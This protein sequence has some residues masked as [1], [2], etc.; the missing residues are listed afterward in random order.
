[1]AST[2]SSAA[3]WD[4]FDTSDLTP[5]AS[6]ATAAQPTAGTTTAPK[7]VDPASI[8]W[9]DFETSDLIH[10]D[11]VDYG[12]GA[13][14]APGAETGMLAQN[15][16]APT[17]NIA[18]KR[19]LGERAG[20]FAELNNGVGG[21]YSPFI[22][23]VSF[24]AMDEISS[25]GLAPVAAGFNWLKG[26]GPTSLGEAYDQEKAAYLRDKALYEEE[27]RILSGA[28]EIAGSVMSGG[29]GAKFVAGA[30]GF[31][32]MLGRSALIG[33]GEAGAYSALDTEGTLADRLKA[34]ATGAAIGAGAGAFGPLA[35]KGLSAAGRGLA[36]GR[37]VVQRFTNPTAA[38]ENDFVR[39]A[40]RDR[41]NWGA[42]EAQAAA[43]GRPSPK[44]DFGT[45]ADALDAAAMRQTFDVGDLAG[46]R[47][48][49]T[50][51]DA[52]N[53]DA[54]AAELVARRAE[55][56]MTDQGAR[57]EDLAVDLMTPGRPDWLNPAMVT[58]ALRQNAQ[59]VNQR[60][61]REA[62][63]NPAS[64]DVWT[65]GVRGLTGSDS[66]QKAFADALQEHSEDFI[67]K[68]AKSPPPSFKVGA[69]GMLDLDG[70]GG[71]VSL[72]FLDRVQKTL[73]DQVEAAKINGKMTSRATR[74]EGF[75][76]QL[77]EEMDRASTVG[78]ESLYG[79]ARGQAKAFFDAEDSYE[80]GM[81][82][83][84][85]QKAM[86]LSKARQA[87]DGMSD[88]DRE[89]FRQG[90]AAA[91]IDKIAKLPDAKDV[92]A[93]LN[94]RAAR[95][96]LRM[97]LGDDKADAFSAY[98][99]RDGLARAM[100]AVAKKA[101]A[102][103][104]GAAL[105]G[106]LSSTAGA[107]VLGSI[108]GALASGDP[109][110]GGTLVGALFGGAGRAIWSRM[111]ASRRQAYAQAVARLVT[112]DDP[113]EI[114]R[115]HTKIMSDPELARLTTRAASYG[116]RD[117]LRD[118]PL[119]ALTEAP[120]AVAPVLSAES[121]QPDRMSI[122]DREDR[123]PGYARGGGVE[124]PSDRTVERLEALSEL[125]RP[126]L[127][128]PEAELPYPTN[129]ELAARDAYTPR[130]KRGGVGLVTP[131]EG[132]VALRDG[133]LVEAEHSPGADAYLNGTGRVEQPDGRT[134]YDHKGRNTQQLN[135]RGPTAVASANS[136]R[137]TSVTDRTRQ[138]MRPERLR[139]QTGPSD[140]RAFIA[141]I[142][143]MIEA[144]MQGAA[145][146]AEPVGGA[147]GALA[148]DTREPK[149]RLGKDRPAPG[150]AEDFLP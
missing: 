13:Y 50:V 34:G 83:A 115:I 102:R 129:E 97:A 39:A 144:R 54:D 18:G 65:V 22:H 99:H 118:A 142:E 88:I 145:V 71:K 42:A 81:K 89:L 36:A 78:G 123:A 148:A 76:N 52:L 126:A 87:I 33:G 51:K 132:V 68:R 84:S 8:G 25:G 14:G 4:G 108:G 82:F 149:R 66:V 5:A 60:A 143:A 24:G 80:A 67:A 131:G 63:D 117:A 61:Y 10:R 48:R 20:T 94:N 147:L 114:A 146:P 53:E 136:R 17:V 55:S 11:T 105:A 7:S 70:A 31:L 21:Q 49:A 128:R 77:L 124:M 141:Q 32:S 19:D 27:N 57:A 73:R 30:P 91:L 104:G 138:R 37:G 69:D 16:E 116:L 125:Y 9:D 92:E 59:R 75:R 47:A 1:M 28:A 26:E 45:A 72:E 41:V 74:I 98:L 79:K 29:A 6:K 134:I 135:M 121:V 133:G 112:S 110:F 140:D 127:R 46:K 111:S 119:K 15:G 106:E 44:M 96:N 130:K 90:Y 58:E 12:N 120:G 139:S 2:S 43:S 56:R 35:E 64:A 100:G 3:I 122:A 86:D 109:L 40:A 93:L 103:D 38:A 95:Q 85:P 113:A 107:A 23:G 62:F 137:S 101:A 150:E